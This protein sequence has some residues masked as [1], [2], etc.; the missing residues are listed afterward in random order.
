MG[1]LDQL[2]SG[3]ADGWTP[4]NPGDTIIG[5]ITALDSR[6]GGYGD[7]PIVTVQ[8]DGTGNLTAIHAFRTVLKNEVINQQPQVGDRIA[9][10]YL[11]QQPAKRPGGSPYHSYKMAL[12]RGAGTP[13][14]TAPANV[15]DVAKAFSIQDEEAF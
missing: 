4:E 5:V 2:D 15:A 1:L 6:D 11:G 8:E 3:N 10:R 9:V 12:E 13:A 14:A 7:Y